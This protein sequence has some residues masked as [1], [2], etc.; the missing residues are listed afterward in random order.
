MKS[1]KISDQTKSVDPDWHEAIVNANIEI[2]EMSLILG[3]WR[4]WRRSGATTV[5]V[6]LHYQYILRKEFLLPVV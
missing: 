3:V 4:T 2:F 1:L 6:R 5:K